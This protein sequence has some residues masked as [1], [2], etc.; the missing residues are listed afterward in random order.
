QVDRVNRWN[1]QCEAYHSCS[2][3]G[4]KRKNPCYKQARCFDAVAASRDIDRESRRCNLRPVSGCTASEKVYESRDRTC[5][6]M[7]VWLDYPVFHS[8]RDA[9]EEIARNEG[10]HEYDKKA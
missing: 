1:S 10:E 8:R 9:E 3:W 2:P 6:E 7:S 5:Q 4:G